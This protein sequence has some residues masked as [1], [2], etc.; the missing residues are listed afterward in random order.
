[1]TRPY[2]LASARIL[3]AGR[4]EDKVNR[5]AGMRA[6]TGERLVPMPLPMVPRLVRWLERRVAR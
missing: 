3:A 5:T 2:S 1:M 4:T 6:K